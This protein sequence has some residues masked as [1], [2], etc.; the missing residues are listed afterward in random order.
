MRGCGAV[1]D[2]CTEF[3]R[4]SAPEEEL[5]CVSCL[6]TG[7]RPR[8]H[9]ALSTAT[10]R[11]RQR[12]AS[13]GPFRNLSADGN[14]VFFESP[15][16]MLPA[17]T[18]GV[19][20]VYEWE[21]KGEGSCESESLNGG[22]LYL[23]SSGS[24]PEN[25]SFL[26]ASANGDHV[27]FYTEQKLVPTDED[28]LVDVYDAGVGAGLAAQHTL[29]PPTCA[30]T[31]CQSNPA[32][33][34]TRR[35]PARPSG[36]RATSTGAAKGRKCPKGKRKVSRKGKVSCK[37]AHNSTNVTTTVEVPSDFGKASVHPQAASP[38]RPHPGPDR[39][40]RGRS[41]PRRR[42]R[43]RPG[44]SGRSR[45][46]RH[47][48]QLHRRRRQRRK[49]LRDHRDQRRLQSHRRHR[50]RSPTSCPKGSACIPKK[51]SRIRATFRCSTTD[52]ERHQQRLLHLRQRSRSAAAARPSFTPA[53]IST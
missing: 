41:C 37:R 18:N 34:P 51:M 13:A 27:F 24:D 39:A 7:T 16:A 10:G 14:R 33:P 17:D 21:A 25:S 48:D 2:P 29:A 43:R 53:S 30:S 47:A 8:R 44:R 52:R 5:L 42:Q 4:Y 45:P 22:C 11:L 38:R 3:F 12:P 19:N 1:G 46:G 9:A 49:H 32:P 23:I 35:P 15:D 6:P 50:S 40:P 31:A 36:A 20:D 26:G 28:R